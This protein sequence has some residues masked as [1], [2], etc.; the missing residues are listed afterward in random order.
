M[1]K[2]LLTIMALLVFC[3]GCGKEEKPQSNTQ[4]IVT[5]IQ[6]QPTE[7]EPVEQKTG[8]Y[9]GILTERFGFGSLAADDFESMY[10]APDKI[11]VGER[12]TTV[13][14]GND[15]FEFNSKGLSY[16]GISSEIFKGPAD[17]RCGMT[18][19]QTVEKL[20]PDYAETFDYSSESFQSVYGKSTYDEYLGMNLVVPYCVFYRLSME[21]A[22]PDGTYVMEIANKTEKGTEEITLYFSTEKILTVYSMQLVA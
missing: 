15:R 7:S 5:S 1:K 3:S 11:N 17:I 22:T 21:N 13:T 18:L 19:E 14:Q 16:A 9:P 10:G 20:L 8:C 4:S 2:A 12:I 6:T